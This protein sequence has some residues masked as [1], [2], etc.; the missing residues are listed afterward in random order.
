MTEPSAA[1]PTEQAAKA[2]LEDFKGRWQELLNF[3]SEVSRWFTLYLTAAIGIFGWV[4]GNRDFTSI[5]LLLKEHDGLNAI[6]VISLALLNGVYVLI[7]AF[8]GYRIQQI[9]QYLYSY[10]GLRLT[11]LTNEPFNVWED[12][13]RFLV[14]Q[15]G[16]YGP[17]WIRKVYFTFV[18]LVPFAVSCL[19]L[20]VYWWAEGATQSPFSGHNVYSYVVA[21]I[22]VALLI[23]ALWTTAQNRQWDRM[24]KKRIAEERALRIF[25]EPYAFEES[26]EPLLATPSGVA[27]ETL[28]QLS[29]SP[30]VATGT[31]QPDSKG[32]SADNK[33]DN[34]T[35]HEPQKSP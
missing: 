28:K 18:G 24:I 35:T 11:K 22:N 23:V 20:G 10:V 1:S 33:P 31:A 4:M 5:Q 26:P 14:S 2:L 13:R 17:E 15:P 25:R 29:P 34:V 8:N 32:E 9:G 27:P 12:W 30:E 7:L 3:E 16:A 6:L 21:A 19:I